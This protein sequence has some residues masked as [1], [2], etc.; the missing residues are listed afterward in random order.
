[1]IW[2]PVTKNLH[3]NIAVLGISV[4][5]FLKRCLVMEKKQK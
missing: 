3:P 2:N 5:P 4:L 1:M